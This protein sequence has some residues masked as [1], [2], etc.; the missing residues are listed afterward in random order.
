MY[1]AQLSSLMGRAV[2]FFFCMLLD[3]DM[4]ALFETKVSHFSFPRMPSV[5]NKTKQKHAV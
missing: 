4:H 3:I 1:I 5:Q 2:T